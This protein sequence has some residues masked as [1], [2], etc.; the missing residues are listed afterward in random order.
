MRQSRKNK[1]STQQPQ[2][3][4]HHRAQRA[5]IRKQV[6]NTEINY[7]VKHMKKPGRWYSIGGMNDDPLYGFNFSH[8]YKA[9]NG[10]IA[11]N[12]NDMIKE[13]IEDGFTFIYSDYGDD[14]ISSTKTAMCFKITFDN[15]SK[16][17]S[18]DVTYSPDCASSKNGQ[19][20]R[21]DGTK[22][23]FKAI[24]SIIMSR[25]DID[26]F[27]AIEL[28]DNA[29]IECVNFLDGSKIRIDLAD[30]CF[31]T[32]GCTWYSN[33]APMFLE[34]KYEE[35]NFEKDRKIVLNSL[36]FGEF[37]E[38]I[39]HEVKDFFNTHIKINDEFKNKRAH[40]VLNDIRKKYYHCLIFKKYIGE[41][42]TAMGVVN[43]FYGKKWIIA[44]KDGKVVYCPEKNE[45]FNNSGDIIKID[46]I[47]TVS[48]DEYRD[49]QEKIRNSLKNIFE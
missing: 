9:N 16:R 3:I 14:I 35:E 28:T 29:F 4:K 5:Y 38:I 20:P 31:I 33:K 34:D 7:L 40:I 21:G 30:M 37:M 12:F 15:R 1:K 32:T 43:S 24:F 6:R 10:N 26:D 42:R 18:V 44:M 11:N 19:L 13:V 41:L 23:M 25:K 45:C 47:M 39:P 27:N 17:I 46:N 49:I 48:I 36:P 22:S 8:N 2:T